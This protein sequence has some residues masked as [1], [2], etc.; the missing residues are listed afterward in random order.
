MRREDFNQITTHPEGAAGKVL[1]IAAILQLNKASQHRTALR[2]ITDFQPHG[3]FGIGLDRAD[4]IDAGHRGDDHDIAAFEQ[5]PRCGMA[6]AVYLF[7][8][9]RIFLDIGVGARHIGFRLVV[10]V[11]GNKILDRVMGK[12]ALHL[13]V[14]LRRQRLVRGEDQRWPPQ[15]LDRLGHGEGLARASDTKQH[16]IALLGV[17]PVDNLGNRGWLIARRFKIRHEVEIGRGA[18]GR[19]V[20]ENGINAI[21]GS[22]YASLGQF[23]QPSR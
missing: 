10:I 21:H 6:H 22:L 8:Y 13:A 17:D 23:F 7:I 3:H 19:T 20:G 12:E 5:R 15:R 9:R 2:H 18:S 16:L 4:T 14:E 11:I 1:V